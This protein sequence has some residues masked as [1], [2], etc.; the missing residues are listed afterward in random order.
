MPKAANDLRLISVGKI[1]ENNKTISQCQPPFG[2]LPG[3]VITMHVVVQPS[4][5]K[6]KIGLC[7]SDFL[8]FQNK[9][10]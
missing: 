8:F 2:E 5:T 4:V 9:E 10:F 6:T 1:L 3:G 7:Y